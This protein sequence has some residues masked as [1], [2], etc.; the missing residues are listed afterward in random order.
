MTRSILVVIPTLNEARTIDGVLEALQQDLPVGVRTTFVVA[1]GGS[2]DGTPDRVTRHEGVQFLR[3]PKRLQSAAVNLAAATCGR[4][5]D[6]LVRCDAQADGR[7]SDVHAAMRA[8][9]AAM[10]ASAPTI[11]ATFFV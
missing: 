2:T 7:D 3:N 10:P 4:D 11:S 1:D 5:A 9:T 6:V 8:A